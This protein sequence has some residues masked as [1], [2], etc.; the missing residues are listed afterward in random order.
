L[1]DGLHEILFGAKGFPC[2]ILSL[3]KGSFPRMFA[4]GFGKLKQT[5]WIV[6]AKLLVLVLLG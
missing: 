4:A 2:I 6:N 3:Q 1:V 5:S